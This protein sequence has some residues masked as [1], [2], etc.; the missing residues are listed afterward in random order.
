[1]QCLINLALQYHHTTSNFFVALNHTQQLPI[2]EWTRQANACRAKE[3]TDGIHCWPRPFYSQLQLPSYASLCPTWSIL[4]QNLLYICRMC[5]VFAQWVAYILGAL[6]RWD[7]IYVILTKSTVIKVTAVA[8]LGIALAGKT[9]QNT[10]AVSAF[11][12]MNSQGLGILQQFIYTVVCG[13]QIESWSFL[14]GRWSRF[15]QI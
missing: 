3:K 12:G 1:M 5:W 2:L 10:P 13:L 6:H 9:F 14:W 8:K 11:S 15:H 7:K 4:I